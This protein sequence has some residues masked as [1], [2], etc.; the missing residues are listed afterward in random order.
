MRGQGNK[1]GEMGLQVARGCDQGLGDASTGG[2]CV[3][4]GAGGA[5]GSVSA[6]E[7]KALT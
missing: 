6:F 5:G 7:R 2:T 4:T 3:G 1:V